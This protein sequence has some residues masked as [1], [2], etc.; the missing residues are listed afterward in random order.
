MKWLPMASEWTF[1]AAGEDGHVLKCVG[2]DAR[3]PL[4]AER[5]WI[6]NNGDLYIEDTLEAE[7][8][9]P[10]GAFLGLIELLQREVT[11]R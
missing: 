3:G 8:E 5:M 1:P 4:R 9:I 11:Q 2:G 7:I 10:K 6:D